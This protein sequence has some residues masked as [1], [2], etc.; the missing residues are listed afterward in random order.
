MV[1]TEFR[2][3]NFEAE[4]EEEA[5]ELEPLFTTADE[6]RTPV[7]RPFGPKGLLGEPKLSAL[8]YRPRSKG[9][10]MPSPK[11]ARLA[12]CLIYVPFR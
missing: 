4:L 3:A 5:P 7:W 12:T 2:W 10:Y 6:R 1:A 11:T 8:I 9:L